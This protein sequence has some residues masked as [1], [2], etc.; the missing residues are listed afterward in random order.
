MKKRELDKTL[1]EAGRIAGEV[2]FFVIGS[3]AV[4]AYCRQPPTEVLLSQECDLYPKNRPEMSNLIE[5][6]MGRG[7]KFARRHGFYAD[8]VTPEIAALPLGWERRLKPLRVSRVTALC[9]EAHDLVVSK[10]AA[11][12]LK[13]LEFI[14][15]LLQR[16]L[17]NPAVVRRRIR[18][19]RSL[20]DR[21][22]LRARLQAVLDDLRAPSLR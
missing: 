2:E 12:R 13:D 20:T 6:Q 10:L 5:A 15:A 8:V 9:L 16:R 17:A 3:Q 11:G 4:H 22:R 18:T 19:F 1:R 14:G 21:R 7:S